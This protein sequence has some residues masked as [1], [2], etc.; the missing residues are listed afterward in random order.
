VPNQNPPKIAKLVEKQVRRLLPKT[1]ICKFELLSSGKPWAAPFHHPI[2]ATAQAALQKGFGKKA[3]FIREGGSIPFVTQMHDTFKVPCVLLG[4]GLPDEN[5]HA[6]DEH[7]A[8]ENYFGGIKAIANFY[9]G[10]GT[11]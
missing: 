4:F 8:L 6:P 1:V 2:F 3:V 11:L 9:S 7:I 10:L 5:A